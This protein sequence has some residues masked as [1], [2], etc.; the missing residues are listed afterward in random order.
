MRARSVFVVAAVL[1]AQ[2][3]WG[4]AG[5][6]AGCSCMGEI[7]HPVWGNEP[8]VDVVFIGT[9]ISS[10]DDASERLITFD[11]EVVRKGV[12]S[13]PQDVRTWTD[14]AACGIA[15]TPDSRYR[16]FADV[17]DGALWTDL[18]NGGAEWLGPK[19]VAIPGP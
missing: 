5:P 4:P 1:V 7:V 3:V 15:V 9:V 11:V 17:R 18:C 14:E 10:V 13:D 16:V 12:V 2:L 19:V 6:A 8:N